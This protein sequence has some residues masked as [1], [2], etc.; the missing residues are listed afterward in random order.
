MPRDLKPM[1]DWSLVK[2][3]L[4]GLGAAIAIVGMMILVSR[5]GGF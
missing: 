1:S 3:A 2:N 4:M 5:W